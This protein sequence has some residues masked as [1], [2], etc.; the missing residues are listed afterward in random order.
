MA[1]V[2]DGRRWR[3]IVDHRRITIDHHRTIGHRWLIS[4]QLAGSGRVMA[5]FGS[6]HGSGHG[7][8]LDRVRHVACH[9]CPRGIHVDADVDNTNIWGNDHLER[10]KGSG[11][12]FD[13]AGLSHR[14]FIEEKSQI[15]TKA[16][17]GGGYMLG[18]ESTPFGRDEMAQSGVNTQTP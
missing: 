14:S 16:S 9:M 12:S 1:A 17:W 4:S 3:T 13:L 7:P 11:N 10:I 5:G 8:G 6:G 15:N 18:F 2:N